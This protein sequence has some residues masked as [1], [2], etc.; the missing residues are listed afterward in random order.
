M[1]IFSILF[2]RLPGLTQKTIG[3]LP[4]D[5][6]TQETIFFENEVTEHPIET[7][8]VI[9]DHIYNRPIGLRVSGTVKSQNRSLGF[10][11][12]QTLFKQ[13]Q[14]IFVV[15]GLQT[16]PQMAI[17]DLIIPRDWETASS[18]QFFASFKQLE[19]VSSAV[20]VGSSPGISNPASSV[21]N[22]A[23]TT[24]NAGQVQTTTASPTSVAGASGVEAATG[25]APSGGRASLL[26]KGASALGGLF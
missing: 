1:A 15:T 11:I 12:L 22:T 26:K 25:G 2:G 16:F 24:T 20:G 6:F 18:L 8:G 21:S 10:E 7:G 19:F 17:T 13:R 4:V 5:V 23:A 3:F 9:T 14:P